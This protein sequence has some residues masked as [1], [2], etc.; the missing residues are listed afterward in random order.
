MAGCRCLIWTNEGGQTTCSRGR[1]AHLTAG[2]AEHSGANAWRPHD[3]F[4]VKNIGFS[5]ISY[6]LS[7]RKSE[8]K[9]YVLNDV[10][11]RRP[12]VAE[13]AWL[14]GEDSNLQHFG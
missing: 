9:Y 1:R 11:K 5:Q 4:F 3:D 6:R 13:R 2:L 7:A 12:Q 14:P 10:K 8:R